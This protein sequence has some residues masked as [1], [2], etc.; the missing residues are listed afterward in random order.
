MGFRSGLFYLYCTI[1]CRTLFVNSKNW[2]R[3]YTGS[4]LFTLAPN[5]NISGR[6]RPIVSP[7]LTRRMNSDQG[8]LDHTRKAKTSV[9]MFQI[10][11]LFPWVPFVG[12]TPPLYFGPRQSS[13]SIVIPTRVKSFP[14][15]RPHPPVLRTGGHNLQVRPLLLIIET[16]SLGHAVDT[17]FNPSYIS[18]RR[19]RVPK[20]ITR[21]PGLLS[22]LPL[23]IREVSPLRVDC[24]RR[25]DFGI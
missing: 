16:R 5:V 15:Y 12:T 22:D 21:G 17:C 20:W 2:F 18:F 10:V 7:P 1:F 6:E 11:S 4:P 13:V 3:H 23:T 25:R 19:F 24:K 8:D 14:F 9:R